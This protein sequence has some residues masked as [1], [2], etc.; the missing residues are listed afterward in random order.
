VSG[1]GAVPRLSRGPC[2]RVRTGLALSTDGSGAVSPLIYAAV[3][4]GTKVASRR[5]AR[6]RRHNCYLE[7]LVYCALAF[8]QSDRVNVTFF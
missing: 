2:A 8:G 3:G 6:L 1:R 5:P 4:S 7:R